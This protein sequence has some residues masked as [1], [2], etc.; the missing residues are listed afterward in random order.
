MDCLFSLYLFIHGVVVEVKVCQLGTPTVLA[1][2]I[3]AASVSRVQ[4][5]RLVFCRSGQ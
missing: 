3:T 5:L 1:M 2:A 4:P